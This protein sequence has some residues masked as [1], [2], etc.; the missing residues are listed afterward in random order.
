VEVVGDPRVEQA[1]GVV[2][3]ADRLATL[4]VAD[5]VVEGVQARVEGVDAARVAVQGDVVAQVRVEQRALDPDPGPLDEQ[6]GRVARRVHAGVEVG[7]VVAGV[8]D[9]VAVVVVLHA[10]VDLHLE[11][12]LAVVLPVVI[13]G[14]GSAADDEALAGLEA[15][16]YARRHARPGVVLQVLLDDVVDRLLVDLLVILFVVL[17]V[18][19]LGCGHRPCALRRLLAVPRRGVLALQH[20]AEFLHLLRLLLDLFLLCRQPGLQ[21]RQVVAAAGARG[22]EQTEAG[23]E[24]APA[25]RSRAVVPHRLEPPCH[26]DAFVPRPSL[27]PVAASPV[28]PVGRAF[29]RGPPPDFLAGRLDRDHSLAPVIFG[30]REDRK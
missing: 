8:G 30:V 2:D 24:Q 13:G 15:G 16:L 6:G 3:V 18:A 22:R 5:G 11:G 20:F 29:G 10:A 19:G 25:Q 28:R 4:D 26:A 17:L 1:D 27:L 7:E 12:D 9:L 23:A 21:V 14:V